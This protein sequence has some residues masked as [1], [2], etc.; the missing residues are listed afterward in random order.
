SIR[1]ECYD[2][3]EDRLG[4]LRGLLGS[5]LPAGIAAGFSGETVHAWL[6]ALMDS[7]E[8]LAYW[9]TSFEGDPNN[10]LWGG[11][12]IKDLTEPVW[13]AL[14][15]LKVRASAA[16]AQAQA[17]PPEVGLPASAAIAEASK[18]GRD[19]TLDWLSK[20]KD[21]IRTRPPQLPGRHQLEVEM[22][23]FLVA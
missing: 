15:P 20:R 7:V 11:A 19:V 5:A 22:G 3:R 4:E 23:S 13:E 1:S 18:L 17:H 21:R 8:G 6:E 9:D 12:Q 16:A 10:E 14:E 2:L